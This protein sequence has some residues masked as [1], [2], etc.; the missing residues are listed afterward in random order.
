M[1]AWYLNIVVSVSY[2]PVI[3]KLISTSLL[4]NIE[5]HHK[6]RDK[7]TLVSSVGV[8]IW[9]TLKTPDTAAA[10][11]NFFLFIFFY[12]YFSEKTS[13]HFI[14]DS[15]EMS[16]L[17]FFLKNKNKNLNVVCTNFAWRFK[18]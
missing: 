11:D 7:L 14:D 6:K 10:D 2:C 4:Y 17:V 15:H 5:R 3:Q 13:Q 8:A 18:G 12:F 1:V 9:L 16:R